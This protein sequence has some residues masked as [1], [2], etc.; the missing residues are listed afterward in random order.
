[1]VSARVSVRCFVML[2]GVLVAFGWPQ[3]LG[4]QQPSASGSVDAAVTREVLDRFCVRCHNGRTRTAG[5][6][7]DEAD[8]A[9]VGAEAETW[10]RVIVKLRSQPMPP[11]CPSCR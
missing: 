5:L 7:F 3:G 9:G 4:A 10:E 6:A 11:A 1:M 2:L 8:L